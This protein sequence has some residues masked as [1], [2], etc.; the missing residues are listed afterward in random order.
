MFY[1]YKPLWSC[2]TFIILPLAVR[3]K[4]VHL[5][6]ILKTMWKAADLGE[7][8]WLHCETTELCLG[9]CELISPRWL[10]LCVLAN[11]SVAQFPIGYKEDNN[12]FFLQ[13]FCSPCL[14]TVNPLGCLFNAQQPTK[15][16]SSLC[17][18]LWY[19]GTESRSEQA[20]KCF[21]RV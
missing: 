2:K 17:N 15:R 4:Y 16:I 8:G 10:S 1:E 6:C 20:L 21:P 19:K 13:C 5:S 9:R 14:C 12:S 11:L 7:E 18:E 3:Q